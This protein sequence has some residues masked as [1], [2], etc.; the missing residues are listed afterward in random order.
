MS[1]LALLLKYEARL[2]VDRLLQA[3]IDSLRAFR[4]N[5]AKSHETCDERLLDERA[6]FVEL[7]RAHT[8]EVVERTGLLKLQLSIDAAKMCGNGNIAARLEEARDRI[9]R[10]RRLPRT[11]ETRRGS[12]SAMNDAYI[13]SYDPN[14]SHPWFVRWPK[15]DELGSGGWYDTESI[16]A[17]WPEVVKDS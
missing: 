8:G 9:L 13:D 4:Q 2:A 10:D 16:L 1:R 6:V 17:F 11:G 5:D 12:N 3:D 7:R 14:I 15:G